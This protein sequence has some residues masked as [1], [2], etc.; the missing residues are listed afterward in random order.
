M[1]TLDT[2]SGVPIKDAP[3]YGKIIIPEEWRDK[4]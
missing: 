3:V 1:I 2:W 4:E